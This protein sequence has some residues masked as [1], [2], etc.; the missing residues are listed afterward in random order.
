MKQAQTRCCGWADPTHPSLLPRLVQNNVFR[1]QPE[2]AADALAEDAESQCIYHLSPLEPSL[3]GGG[4][5]RSSR[6]GCPRGCHLSPLSRRSGPPDLGPS[7][8]L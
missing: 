7:S 6:R 8:R 5:R 1:L 3:R 4:G 2:E